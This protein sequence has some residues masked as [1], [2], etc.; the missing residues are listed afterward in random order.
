[1]CFDNKDSYGF[2]RSLFNCALRHERRR[3]NSE[4]N[5]ACGK[6]MQKQSGEH[7]RRGSVG[8]AWC[9]K[10]KSSFSKVCL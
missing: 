8:E 9:D 10:K 4:T 3:I 2:I 1:M 7:K 6:V 5:K